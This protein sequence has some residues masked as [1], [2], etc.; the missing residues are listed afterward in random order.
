MYGIS[1]DVKWPLFW[2]YLI[3]SSNLSI[4]NETRLPKLQIL[5]ACSTIT[6]PINYLHSDTR[7]THSDQT[8]AQSTLQYFWD[9]TMNIWISS[10]LLR[11]SRLHLPQRWQCVRTSV[12]KKEL[13]R[14]R[15]S[16]MKCLSRH[17]IRPSINDESSKRTCNYIIH[18]KWV[19]QFTCIAAHKQTI[20]AIA[21][22][23]AQR[24]HSRTHFGNNVRCPWLS[25]IG[26]GFCRSFIAI[27]RIYRA[28]KWAT[29]RSN[30]YWDVRNLSLSHA[31]CSVGHQQW[32]LK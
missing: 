32:K 1:S 6:W 15:W 31:E 17:C 29:E 2:F 24:A 7:T 21:Y 9:S 26:L 10:N 19:W 14:C 16:L 4:L 8:L 25:R 23:R 22:H 5:E 18:G 27:W 3:A 11:W 20:T 30:M 13:A 28:K 12:F